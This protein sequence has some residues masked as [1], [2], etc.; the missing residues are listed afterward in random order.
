MGEHPRTHE[1]AELELGLSGVRCMDVDDVA[2]RRA[3]AV[4][5]AAMTKKRM[6]EL[7]E[8]RRLADADLERHRTSI[9]RLH[10][11][12]SDQPTV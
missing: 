11:P 2:R 6:N 12:L 3:A 4:S 8:E 7:V 10:M 9:I 5:D 1:E